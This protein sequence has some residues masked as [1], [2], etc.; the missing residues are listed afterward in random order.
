MPHIYFRQDIPLAQLFPDGLPCHWLQMATNCSGI[1]RLAFPVDLENLNPFQLRD[2]LAEL[3]S[4]HPNYA[5]TDDLKT[6][7]IAIDLS[8]AHSCEYSPQELQEIKKT[9]MDLTAEQQIRIF[10]LICGGLHE[11]VTSITE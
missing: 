4:K 11:L 10:P 7:G 8:Q 5:E 9:W 6:K 2:L 1:E 3:E